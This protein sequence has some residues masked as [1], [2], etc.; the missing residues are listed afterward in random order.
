MLPV[1][2]PVWRRTFLALFAL[3]VR[4]SSLHHLNL[5]EPA[6]KKKMTRCIGKCLRGTILLLFRWHLT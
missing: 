1:P 6:V 3:R 5:R 2:M 4:P